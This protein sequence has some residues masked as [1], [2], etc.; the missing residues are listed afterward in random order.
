M[1]SKLVAVT[2][3][4]MIACWASAAQAGLLDLNNFSQLETNSDDVDVFGSTV[5]FKE[6]LSD[7][8]IVLFDDFFQVTEASTISFDY[9]FTS[10]NYDEFDFGDF[11]QFT[12]NFQYE[13]PVLAVTNSGSGH[14]S[15]DLSA[16]VGQEIS[17]E[18]GLM[19]GGL[20]YEGLNPDD[21]I[22]CPSLSTATVSNIRLDSNSPG[23]APV[24]EPG[25]LLLF[26]T[27]LAAL[28]RSGRRQS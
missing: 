10:D 26:G 23:T 19:W 18:W 15:Y 8:A 22:Y 1:R 2:M 7:A 11:F 9:S 3:S 20:T 14:F 17:I 28:A 5:Y 21:I 24:P 16:F 27:G 13:P 12:I 6:N 4:L 25:T